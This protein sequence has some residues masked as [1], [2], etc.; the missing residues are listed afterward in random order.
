MNSNRNS[1]VSGGFIS[2]QSNGTD[3]ASSAE[4]IKCTSQSGVSSAVPIKHYHPLRFQACFL[5]IFISQSVQ[6]P[7]RNINS[8]FGFHGAV[9]LSSDS[10]KRF[11]YDVGAYNSDDDKTDQN[12]MGDFLNEMA[13]M[14]NL[15]IVE[16]DGGG[17]LEE[18]GNRSKD[19]NG[20]SSHKE[21]GDTHST[22]HKIE[23]PSLKVG[24]LIGKGGEIVR[25]L[26]LSSALRPVEIIG[27]L[28]SIEK[29]EKLISEVIAQSEG[30]GIHALFVGVIIGQ[31]DYQ[32]HADK[33]ESTDSGC[34]FY[35]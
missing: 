11:V 4:P 17:S 24:K 9:N 29:A 25:N 22:T 26:Q 33:V 20:G 35:L 12:G 15:C 32:E 28:A 10:N 21:V 6:S 1:T 34:P 5:V 16:A 30:E 14:M 31:G 7:L 27:N 8:P 3:G 2:K 19:V 13:A 23:V 18:G